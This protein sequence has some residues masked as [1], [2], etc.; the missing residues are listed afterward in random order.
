MSDPS[1]NSLLYD[2]VDLR[3]DFGH[4]GGEVRPGNSVLSSTDLD[5]MATVYF[6]SG[7]ELE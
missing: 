6:T 4:Q 5:S 1:L 2:A 3:S 7:R